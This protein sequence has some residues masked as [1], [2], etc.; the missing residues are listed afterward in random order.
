MTAL[1]EQSLE[2]AI[3]QLAGMVENMEER[4]VMRPS[5]LI[6]PPSLFKL[7][8]RIIFPHYILKRRKGVRG[9]AMTLKWR[10]RMNQGWNW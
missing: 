2:E 4:I 8:R 3:M 5:H 1:T 6:V 9:R 7:S 10:R